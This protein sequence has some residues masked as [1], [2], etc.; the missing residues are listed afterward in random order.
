MRG[1]GGI[2]VPKDSKSRVKSEA[3]RPAPRITIDTP[4][5]AGLYGG[6]PSSLSKSP[7]FLRPERFLSDEHRPLLSYE[8]PP[9]S[10][11]NISPPSFRG[12]DN[13]PDHQNLLTVPGTS[14]R[15]SSLDHAHSDSSYGG[16]TFF[17]TPTLLDYD[18]FNGGPRRPISYHALGND[19]PFN[20]NPE[21]HEFHA[22]D[23]PFAFSVEQ[24][25][26]LFNPK[27][28]KAF[29]ALGGL[30]G[31]A[32]GL[33]TDLSGGLSLDETTLDGMGDLGKITL[34]TSSLFPR[35]VYP[36]SAA[37]VRSTI[38]P[39]E[40]QTASGHYADRQ[41]IFGTNR[42]PEKKSKNLLQVMWMTFNDKVLIILTIV[43]TISLILGLYQDFGRSESY[44]GPKVRWV[45]G[46]TIM[47]A[48]AIV[49]VV[50]SLNDFQKEKQFIKL[51]KK[52]SNP[53][54]ALTGS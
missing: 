6:G 50:G 52:V 3:T 11:C 48:V 39:S 12:N 31:L 44:A 38:S 47:V 10:P 40:R 15:R 14:S 51:N 13:S 18:G 49:V 4:A 35:K 20:A 30:H 28:L 45:E 34:P 53:T 1:P 36:A 33:R 41:R 43:A 24:L 22:E 29:R 42:L 25:S 54:S 8:S 19:G 32:I 5:V 23:N 21:G 17:S 2:S 7:S 16:E 26:R 46:V 9:A 37:P 27:S